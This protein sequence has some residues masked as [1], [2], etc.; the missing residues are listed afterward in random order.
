MSSI[1]RYKK[2]LVEIQDQWESGGIQYASVKA[3]HGEP[4]MGGDKWPI[5]TA[6][7]NA[8]V[9]ELEPVID[10]AHPANLLALALQYTNKPQW[11]AGESIFIWG[12]RH[13]GAFLK[14]E[15]GFVRLSLINYDPSCLIFYLD[16]EGWT[17][18][19]RVQESYKSWARKAREAVK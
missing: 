19:Q 4:F 17:V 18:S 7:T 3:L 5:H 2:Q 9:D 12:D 10:P 11:Y 15:G 1:A 14:E 16:R 6:Q 13:R 8:P